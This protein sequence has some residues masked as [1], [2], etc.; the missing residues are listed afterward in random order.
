[1][2]WPCSWV[3]GGGHML[4]ETPSH[5]LL[6]PPY[7]TVVI[8]V[9]SCHTS[10]QLSY[11]CTVVILVYS[12]HTGVQLSYQCTV[13]IPVY[14]CHTGVQL[15][16]WCT[17]VI[18]VYSCHTGVQLSYRCTVVIP[19]YTV[20]LSYYCPLPAIIPTITVPFLLLHICSTA[21][22]VLLLP[23]SLVPLIFL[24]YRFLHNIANILYS[25]LKSDLNTTRISPSLTKQGKHAMKNARLRELRTCAGSRD[26]VPLHG[27]GFLS[28]GHV[29][30][31]LYRSE[32]P[33]GHHKASLTLVGAGGAIQVGG[34]TGVWGAMGLGR[35]RGAVHLWG[36]QQS[37]ATVLSWL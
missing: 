37:L 8:P 9:Y 6:Q 12:C 19:V 36:R 10:V 27:G 17:V 18:P 24:L 16:Y 14:S 35:R 2:R 30:G 29:H 32:P 22:V 31:A 33:I 34:V 13:V 21:P 20:Q 28:T 15:S 3:W 7:Y 1:M 23:A 25:V 5:L 11:Q 4:A 26:V